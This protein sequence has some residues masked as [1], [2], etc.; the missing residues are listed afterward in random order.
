M[1]GSFVDRCVLVLVI[2]RIHRDWPM[3]SRICGGGSSALDGNRGWV[4]GFFHVN[5]VSNNGCALVLD[6]GG[7]VTR[8]VMGSASIHIA[9]DLLSAFSVVGN[10]PRPVLV[11][12]VE[13]VFLQCSRAVLRSNLWDHSRHIIR[14]ALP[15]L[16]TILADVSNGAIDG[17][18]YDAKLPERIKSTMY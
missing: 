1:Y 9:A 13:A 15:S 18:E 2:G 11:T 3:T 5:P 4:S 12:K 14:D 16:G 6:T 17:Q 10:P 7:G 8:R